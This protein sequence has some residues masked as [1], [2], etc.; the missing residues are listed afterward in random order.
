[1]RTRAMR[2]YGDGEH[3]LLIGGRACGSPSQGALTI[4]MM[5]TVDKPLLV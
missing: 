1:M 2:C 3:R 5:A 4:K